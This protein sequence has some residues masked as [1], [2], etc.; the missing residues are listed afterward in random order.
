MENGWP[1]L[2]VEGSE[3]NDNL[4]AYLENHDSNLLPN[5]KWKKIMEEG[6]I[7]MVKNNSEDIASLAHFALCTEISKD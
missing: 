5:H 3:T 4:K 7:F 1:V 2:F 6:N